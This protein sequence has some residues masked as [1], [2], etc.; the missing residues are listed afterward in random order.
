MP[1][2]DVQGPHTIPLKV[3][4]QEAM[5]QTLRIRGRSLVHRLPL[6]TR[7]VLS[8]VEEPGSFQCLL[9][10]ALQ[11]PRVHREVFLLKEIQGH[12]T[13]EIAAILGI[14]VETALL[15]LKRARREIGDWKN[16]GNA[17]RG[18]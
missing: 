1:C 17:E 11:L 10:R 15:R 5:K 14:T 9:L 4:G 16:S 12:T 8:H 13:R 7:R 2:N 3:A 18:K 6:E